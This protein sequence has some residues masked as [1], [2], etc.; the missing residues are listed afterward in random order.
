MSTSSAFT[1]SAVVVLPMCGP[2]TRKYTSLSVIGFAGSSTLSLSAAPTRSSTGESSV[3]ASM[4]TPATTMPSASFTS[5]GTAPPT[6]VSVAW[7]SPSTT[8]FARLTLIVWATSYT[9]GV[10]IRCWP[11]AS[12]LLMSCTV[13]SGVAMKNS[14]IGM[15]RPAVSP[16][17]QVTPRESCCAAG[18]RTL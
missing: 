6:A 13:S 16:S 14:V 18:T 17:A 12:A 4:V 10:R 8:V 15:L 11:R 7:P 1:S 5:S 9:P 3:P 2:P